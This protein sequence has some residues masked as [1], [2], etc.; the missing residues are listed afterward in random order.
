MKNTPKVI[1]LNVGDGDFTD[2]DFTGLTEVTWCVDRQGDGDLE[3][4]LVSGLK[5]SHDEIVDIANLMI[6]HGG[7]FANAL[8]KAIL[9]ADMANLQILQQSFPGLF[10]RY[11][12][13]V[14]KAKK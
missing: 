4:R 10:S 11:F 9:L 7:S 13:M 5:Y 12:D 6:T 3:Y 8:G 1:F 2:V 14:Q